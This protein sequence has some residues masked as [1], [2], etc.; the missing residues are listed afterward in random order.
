MKISERI[1]FRSSKA[2]SA[3][4]S[5]RLTLVS[6]EG[7]VRVIQLGMRSISSLAR[8]WAPMCEQRTADKGLRAIPFGSELPFPAFH[9]SA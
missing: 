2:L 5:C 3:G 8:T 6:G 7:K 1:A 4:L 9:I